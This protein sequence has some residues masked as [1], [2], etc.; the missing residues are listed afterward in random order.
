MKKYEKQ[1]GI[2]KSDFDLF[3]ST[4]NEIILE[5]KDGQQYRCVY[6]GK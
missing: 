6:V 1:F 4:D 2:S 5:T 3:I